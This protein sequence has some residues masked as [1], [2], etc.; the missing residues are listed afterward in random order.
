MI[1]VWAGADF[2]MDTAALLIHLWT[3]QTWLTKYS[4]ALHRRLRKAPKKMTGAPCQAVRFCFIPRFGV[5]Q[6]KS[7]W[8]CLCCS[9]GSVASLVWNHL[10]LTNSEDSKDFSQKTRERNPPELKKSV[11]VNRTWVLKNQRTSLCSHLRAFPKIEAVR[12][13]EELQ[14][15]KFY[16]LCAESLKSST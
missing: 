14:A 1:S 6:I 5:K 3:Q 4:F 2:S 11:T 9:I 12:R 8:A 13:W 10:C 16:N 7:G 15:N